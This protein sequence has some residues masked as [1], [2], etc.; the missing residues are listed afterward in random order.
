MQEDNARR[1]FARRRLRLD[2]EGTHTTLI[3]TLVSQRSPIVSLSARAVAAH[4]EDIFP[5]MFPI[6]YNYVLSPE[7]ALYPEAI[8]SVQAG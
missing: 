4:A 5:L 6:M 2:V 8:S 3:G 1:L 7:M